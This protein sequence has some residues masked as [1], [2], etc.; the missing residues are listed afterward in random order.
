MTV[1]VSIPDDDVLRARAVALISSLR[2]SPDIDGAAEL[3]SLEALFALIALEAEMGLPVDDGSRNLE[4]L[5]SIDDV[6]REVR[7]SASP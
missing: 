7:M 2:G 1:S 6:I 3:D 4:G 5:T